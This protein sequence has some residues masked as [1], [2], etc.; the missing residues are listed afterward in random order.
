MKQKDLALIIVIVFVS[1]MISF[2]TSN[3]FISPP[4]HDEEAAIVEPITA[5]FEEPDDKYIND[6][7]INPTQQITIGD[8]AATQQNPFGTNQ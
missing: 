7:S 4:K 8:N 1:G 2:F 6:Q 5:D 3:K